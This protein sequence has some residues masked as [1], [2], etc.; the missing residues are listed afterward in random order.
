MQDLTGS[1]KYPAYLVNSSMQAGNTTSDDPALA[2]TAPGSTSVLPVADKLDVL[3]MP[4]WTPGPQIPVSHPGQHDRV[5]VVG[6]R[7]GAGPGWTNA[8][9]I[10]GDGHGWKELS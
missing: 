8:H 1:S 10:P 5:T 6:G 4:Q 3:P 7:D 9:D 2:M